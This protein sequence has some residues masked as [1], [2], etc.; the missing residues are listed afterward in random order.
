MLVFSLDLE[1]RLISAEDP[2]PEPI[3]ASISVRD[4]DGSYDTELIGQPDGIANAVH[5]VLETADVVVGHSV[6]YDFLCLVKHLPEL[7]P[8]IL[9]AYERL[10]ITDTCIREKLL[11]LSNHGRIQSYRPTK[12]SPPVKLS[13]HLSDLEATYLGLDRSAW[14]KGEDAWRM[15][16]AELVGVPANEYPEEAREYALADAE[17]TLR[18]YYAQEEARAAKELSTKTEEFQAR[19]DFALN[20]FTD[21]GICIDPVARER[22]REQVEQDLAEPEKVLVER[23]FLTPGHDGIPYKNGAKDEDGNVK[24]TKPQK[25][26]LA[27]KR[28]KEHVAAACKAAAVEP[29]RTEKGAVSLADDVLVDLAPLLGD[30]VLDAYVE[31]QKVRKLQTTELP[32]L[33]TDVIRGRYDVLKETGRTSCRKDRCYPSTNLQNID[34]RVRQCYAPRRGAVLCSVDYSSLEL[35]SLAQQSLRLF[36]YSKLAETLNAGRD[37]HAF[38]G[39]QLAAKLDPEFRRSHEAKEP[40]A[41]YEAFQELQST[42]PALFRKYRKFAKPTGLG[43]PGGLGPRTFLV[44]AKGTYGVDLVEEFG[45][46]EKALEVAAELKALWLDTYPE[47]EDFFRHVN[48]TCAYGWGSEQQFQYVTP[49]GMVRRGADYCSCCNG[50]GMQSPSAEGAKEACWRLAKALATPG[51]F[52]DSGTRPL[53]FIHDEILAEI[54]EGPRELRDRCA[55]EIE[56]T[57]VE[58]MQECFPDVLVRA[59]PALMRRW[60]KDAEMVL[61]EDGLLDVWEG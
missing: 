14:K 24:R 36:G 5:F 47:M 58:A 7:T 16:Y 32:R 40:V 42:D 46:E 59:E 13:Y 12:D 15:R 9:D 41:R 21:T 4:E 52:R 44:F 30:E 25:A 55:R 50:L 33:E 19:A 34:S 35:V 3:C 28:L 23:G 37:A 38:L 45:S 17:N 10:K 31:R 49:L 54:P 48:D 57:M 20:C 29:V 1:T 61:G 18:I 6:G 43:Y 26:K 60:D 56:R 2:F 53:A 51:W 39:A 8:A 27:E 11:N 22:L